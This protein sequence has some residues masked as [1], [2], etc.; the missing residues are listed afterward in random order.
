MVLDRLKQKPFIVAVDFDG[1]ICSNESGW[2]REIYGTPEP[3][4]VESLQKLRDRGFEIVIFTV[5]AF[6]RFVNGEH[7]PSQLQELHDWLLKYK[8]PYDRIHI[9]VSKP[10]AHIFV[11]DKAV[12]YKK[13]WKEVLSRISDKLDVEIL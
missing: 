13:S 6:S 7:E 8:I 9:D 3:N 10:I 12:E 11:D 4:V 5:R 1:T 2:K